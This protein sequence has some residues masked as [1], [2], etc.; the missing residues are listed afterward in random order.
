MTMMKLRSD[1]FFKEGVK[2]LKQ[3]N[4]ELFKPE[5]DIVAYSVCKNSQFSLDNLLRGFLLSNKIDPSQDD[6]IE[7]L[8]KKCIKI[9]A[10]FEKIDIGMITCSGHKIDSRYCTGVKTV[11]A[12]FDAADSVDTLLRKAKM[13]S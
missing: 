9:D 10:K 12:C 4:E 7:S 11:L 13:Y 8:L 3:A 2:K 1:A 5:E 6:S